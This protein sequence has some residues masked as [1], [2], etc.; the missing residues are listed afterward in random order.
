M[1]KQTSKLKKLGYGIGKFELVH[2]SKIYTVDNILNAWKE[3][4]EPD[5]ESRGIDVARANL[6]LDSWFI[7]AYALGMASLTLWFSRYHTGWVQSLGHWLTLAPFI[8]GVL[9]AIENKFL[10]DILSTFEKNQ[11]ISKKIT[12]IASSS[13][14]IKF[15][16]L[17]IVLVYWIIGWVL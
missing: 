6:K 9:D 2:F 8:A 4:P 7:L 14:A 16:L 15:G 1:L 13:A 12:L 10:L 5:Q 11:D 3:K 17:F